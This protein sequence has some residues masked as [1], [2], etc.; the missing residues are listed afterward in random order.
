MVQSIEEAR[1]RQARQGNRVPPHNLQAEESLLGAMLLSKDAISI[2]AEVCRADDFYKPA[3]GHIFDAILLLHARGE[4][5]DPVTVADELRRHG[6]LDAIGGPSPLVSLQANTPATS[7]AARYAAIVEEYGLLRR[8]I[9]VAGEIAELGYAASEDVAETL[10]RA[11][12]MVFEVAE[13]KS[14]ESTSA[15]RDLLFRALERLEHLHTR[16]EEITGVPTGYT[17]LDHL[18]S[19]LQPAT[20]VIVGARPSMGKTSFAL[21]MAHSAAVHHAR[22]TLYFSLEMGHLELTQR[23]LCST[24]E[25]ESTRLRNGRLLESDWPKIHGAMA[26]L[27]E[28]PLYI[29]DNPNLTVMEVR[30]KARRLKSKL[31]RLDLVVID[32]LQ[33]MSGRSQ[34]E[35]RQ[36]EIAEM[37]RGLKILARELDVP[38]VALSQLSRNLE[39]R[40]D[41]RPMLSDLRESGC[42][43][44]DVRVLRADTGAEESLG[45]LLLSRVENIPVWSIGP[46]L[47]LVRAT[48]RRVFPS[49]IKPVFEL[50][51]SSGRRLTASANHRFLTVDGWRRLD[52]LGPTSRV[53][54]PRT[55]G[56]PD[57]A[58]AWTE[59]QV[60]LL[61][62]LL[63]DGC[64]ALRQPLCY[65]ST[66]PANLRAVEWAAGQLGLSPRRP[67]PSSR[68][69]LDLSMTDHLAGEGHPVCRWLEALGLHGLHTK[70]RFVPA[71]VF[72][73][74]RRRLIL[75]LRHLWAA[76]G[77]AGQAKGQPR[78][79]F[80]APSRRLL[81][82]IQALLVRFEIPSRIVESAPHPASASKPAGAL[83]KPAGALHPAAPDAFVLEVVGAE[84]QIRFL[85]V[86][87]IY[88]DRA[89]QVPTLRRR[90]AAAGPSRHR[91]GDLLPANVWERV[92]PQLEAQALSSPLLAEMIGVDTPQG[93]GTSVLR[94][95]P[96]RARLAAAAEVAHDEALDRLAHADV[97]WD[98]VVAIEPKGEEPVYDA[99][100][101]ET[102]NFIANGAVVH[103]SLEQDADVVVFIYRDEMYNPDS[104]DRGLAEIL[105]S[106]H[107]NGPTGRTKLVFQERYTR[108]DNAARGL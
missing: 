57:A 96:R 39:A 38:V 12:S 65:T 11:E 4:P 49:G 9:G 79:S 15:L 16:G 63:G 87:G 91:A 68:P 99:T 54:V 8:L 73:L 92:R 104:T 51:L 24:A 2:G 78:V 100:V 83:P 33:L 40:A 76:G 97:Q 31:G 35:N 106:K 84:H 53:A 94:S 82:G 102:H 85:D 48:M 7:S 36:I 56:A 86:I 21:G 105:L 19:G 95:A 5:A 6:L 81:E 70:D 52:E 64:S 41:K 75:F 3:H 27:G 47:K 37:S 20:L 67:H 71:P 18:L 26:R 14:T 45:E 62:H 61:A 1:R 93:D 30:A 34:A 77:F 89:W 22:P 107:R 50:R 72:G 25:V 88:G 46:D 29:D 58:T 74:G 66:D 28:A 32:Y 17:D 101:E 55:L 23:L 108:F 69:H 44:A 43:T 13:R 59:A 80:A 103:N 42:L 10:D 90:L 98:R 60:L